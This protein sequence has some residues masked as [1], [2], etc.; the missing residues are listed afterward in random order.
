MIKKVF[1]FRSELKR[2]STIAYHIPTQGKAD[3]KVLIKGAPQAIQKLL[4]TVPKQYEEAYKYYTK[5][6]YRLLA[7]ASKVITEQ[8]LQKLSK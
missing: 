3:L 8:E 1:P 5:Q 2:M 4:K 6:G 7:L